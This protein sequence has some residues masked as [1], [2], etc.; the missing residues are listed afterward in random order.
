MD[1]ELNINEN[2]I[3]FIFFL[4][5]WLL[6][7]CIID[8]YFFCFVFII[9]YFFILVNKIFFENILWVIEGFIFF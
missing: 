5:V 6:N 2:K 9:Y 1:V 3:F 4:L 7:G 8:G